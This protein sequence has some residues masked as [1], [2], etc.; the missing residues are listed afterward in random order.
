MTAKPRI[1]VVDDNRLV[2]RS[3][4][5]ALQAAGLEVMQA[6]NGD[7]AI[8]IARQQAPDLALLDIRMDGMS[9][10]DLADYLRD[11]LA[12]PFVFFSGLADEATRSR[13]RECG[14]LRFLAKPMESAEIVRQVRAVLEAVGTRPSRQ[15][16]APSTPPEAVLAWDAVSAAVGVLMHRHGLTRAQAWQRLCHMAEEQ[17]LGPTAQAQRLLDAVEELARS[18]PMR[19]A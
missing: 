19:S 10:F 12:I 13:A 8:L 16:P 6:L 2:Q 11:V 9:G 7:E 17:G 15:A 14:A 1:L 18:T 5:H 3:V 4:A